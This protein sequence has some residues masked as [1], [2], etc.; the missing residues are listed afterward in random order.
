MKSFIFL[1]RLVKIVHILLD[2]SVVIVCKKI[3]SIQY[4]SVLVHIEI[5]KKELEVLLMLFWSP[6]SF[7]RRCIDLIHKWLRV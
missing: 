2:E 3:Y 7:Y 4:N 5:K 6:N 1:I